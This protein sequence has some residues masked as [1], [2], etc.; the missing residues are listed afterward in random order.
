MVLVT[1]VRR[2]VLL[3]TARA[4]VRVLAIVGREIPLGESG[5]RELV[6]AVS[7]RCWGRRAEAHRCAPAGCWSV[8]G[9]CGTSPAPRSTLRR[10]SWY[11]DRQFI[12]ALCKKVSMSGMEGT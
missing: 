6:G 8:G 9:A 12:I 4:A 5:R 11:C 3:A 1:I 10:L 2:V 7:A